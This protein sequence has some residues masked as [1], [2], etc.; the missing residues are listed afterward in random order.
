MTTDVVNLAND[1]FV[2]YQIDCF[3]VIFHI[4]PVAYILALTVSPFVISEIMRSYCQNCIKIYDLF[5]LYSKRYRS[6]IGKN[7]E[8][9]LPNVQF[10]DI[11]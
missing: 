1:S 3:T 9:V 6:S 10:C 11:I 8:F 2:D 7:Y 5:V 4:E